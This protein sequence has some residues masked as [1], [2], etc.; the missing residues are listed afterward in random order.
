MIHSS[1][2]LS[3]RGH[4]LL[5][6]TGCLALTLFAFLAAMYLILEATDQGLRE[7][8]RRALWAAAVPAMIAIMRFVL[9]KHAAPQIGGRSPH[10]LGSDNHGACGY[11]RSRT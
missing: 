7:F 4:Y 8:R 3:V 10:R 2:R 6:L 5:R 1:R 9:A 11:F